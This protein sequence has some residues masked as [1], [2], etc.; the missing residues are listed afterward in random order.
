[1]MRAAVTALVGVLL[2][3][4]AR[5]EAAPK[6]APSATAPTSTP[7]APSQAPSS[8]GAPGA[9]S[10][11]PSASSALSR[12]IPVEEDF[13]DEADS[14]VNAQSLDAQLDALE[15]EILKK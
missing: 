7:G 14:S 6:P 15:K 5:E 8:S 12:E 9:P 4:C 11:A 2:V 13:E 10:A 1:M 3:A